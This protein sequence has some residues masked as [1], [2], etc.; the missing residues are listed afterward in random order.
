MSVAIR[1]RF[2]DVGEYATF[3]DGSGCKVQKSK[4]KECDINRIVAKY[5]KT[6]ILGDPAHTRK[7]VFADCTLVGD[8]HAM[9]NVVKDAD[10]AFMSLPPAVRSRFGNDPA[11]AYDFVSKTENTE[12]AVKLGLLPKSA[13]PK[14]VADPNDPEKV[15][16]KEGDKSPAQASDPQPEKVKDEKP[17]Q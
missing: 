16:V 5:K 1:G 4:A 6:G 3:N 9:Q 14:V 13:L 2:N 10:R 11:R 15:V 8:Y 17:A 12:E 7:P